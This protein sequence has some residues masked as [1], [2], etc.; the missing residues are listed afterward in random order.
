MEPSA[1]Q[2][3]EQKN[4]AD[5]QAWLNQKSMSGNYLGKKKK[6]QWWEQRNAQ[7]RETDRKSQ[8]EQVLSTGKPQGSILTGSEAEQQGQLA[9]LNLAALGYG[10]GL[11]QTGQEIQGVKKKMQERTAQSGADP[12]SA[13]IMGQKQSALAGAQ[14]SLQASGAKGAAAAGALEAVGRQ[15]DADIAAS[16]YGQQ[17]T[18]L[19]DEKS[20]LSNILGGTVGLMQGEKAA[21][22]PQ[23]AAPM[24]DQRGMLGT[25]IC[26]ELYR[27]GCMD[28]DLYLKD[29][30]YGRTKSEEVLT[31]YVFI[32]SPIVKLM[33]N[34]K[35]FTN[36]V[37]VPALSWANHIANEKYSTFGYFCQ[38]IGE[39]I[40]GLIGKLLLSF[41]R[42]PCTQK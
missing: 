7:D 21:N 25:V 33:Q 16:L 10:Q 20:L 2:S 35:M 40:C 42:T 24:Q 6:A 28:K 9:G 27:Q 15:R 14:R 38:K 17:R 11:Q 19:L 26:T 12:V 37:K 39:P 34:S 8:A 22:I 31:G 30:E 5:F 41:R 36:I 29:S 13:A 3:R 1:Q 4:Q 32:A 23:P 18:S